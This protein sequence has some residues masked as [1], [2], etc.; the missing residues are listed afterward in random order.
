MVI[1]EEHQVLPADP[2]VLVPTTG[3]FEAVGFGGVG[4]DPIRTLF[5]K[6]AVTSDVIE[7]EVNAEPDAEL[8]GGLDEGGPL[9]GGAPRLGRVAEEGIG[10]EEVAG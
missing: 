6:P 4:Q 5:R 2:G 1:I 8:S 9:F 7:N 3:A 10:F